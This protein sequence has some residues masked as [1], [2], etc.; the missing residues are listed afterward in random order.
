MLV[1]PE[2]IARAVAF[3]DLAATPTIVGGHMFS[4][5]ERSVLHAVGEGVNRYRWFWGPVNGTIYGHDFKAANLRQTTGL[6]RRVDVDYNGW[7][8]C[9]IPTQVVRRLGLSLPVFIKWDDAEYGLRAKAAGFPTVTLPGAAVWHVPWTDK[10]DTV[11][12]QAYFHARNRLLVALLYSPYDRGGRVVYESLNMQ[13]K[14]ALALQYSAAELRLLALEDLLRGPE[15]LHQDLPGKLTQVRSIRQ[16]YH[17]AQVAKEP[18]SFPEVRRAK[19]PKKG[20]EPSE[21]RSGLGRVTAAATGAL[22]QVLPVK[23]LSTEH[24]EAGIAAMDAKWW[25]LAQFDSAVVSTADGTGASWHKRDRRT[26][27]DL[28]R[29]SVVLH[30]RV[31]REWPR[32]RETYRE[33]LGDVVSPQSW[34]HTFGLSGRPQSQQQPQSQPHPDRSEQR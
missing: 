7:W 10:D 19:P 14:H 25:L 33:A 28:M 6:H 13:L 32:L 15:R 20:R 1:E 30:E 9:L 5:Y 12:W 34:E 31:A 23:H 27:L 18:G 4:M 26:F 21:P 29:R 24:P 2:G 3:A 16:G 17:D 22:R 11:D 8:M